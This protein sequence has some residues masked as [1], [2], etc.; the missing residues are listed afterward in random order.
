MSNLIL[1]QRS[2][3]NRKKLAT[4]ISSIAKENNL[5]TEG[6]QKLVLKLISD[7]IKLGKQ[8][9]KRRFEKN[10]NGLNAANLNSFLIDQVIR[11]LYELGTLN[12]YRATN[13]TKSERLA[14]VAIGG[15]GRSELA[16]YSDIDLLFLH[17]YKLAF[18]CEQVIEYILY[19][20]WDL[21]FKLGHS[22]RTVK[23]CIKFSKFDIITKTSILESRY[24]CGDRKLYNQLKE[25]YSKE[26]ITNSKNSFVNSKLIEKNLRYKKFGE[27]RY[28]VEPNI[29]EG[30]GSLRDLQTIFWV[31][32]YSSN[33]EKIDQLLNQKVFTHNEINKY[34]KA[35][36]F[37]W[38]VRF[39]LHYLAG[40]SEER[41]TF[42]HQVEIS[43]KLNFR[44]SKSNTSVERFMKKYYLT[45][46]DVGSLSKI[47]FSNMNSEKITNKKNSSRK[48]EF[49]LNKDEDI[50]VNH[51]NNL[52][53]A[54]EKIFFEKPVNIIKLFAISQSYDIDIHPKTITILIRN[55]YRIYKMR[56]NIESNSIFIKILISK[57]NPEKILRKMNE[58]GFIGRFIPDFGKVVAQT[59]HD[60]YHLYT[61]DEHTIRAIGILNRIESG[62]LSYEH[63]LATTIV[64]KISSRRVLYLSVF[65]HDIAKGQSGDHSILGEKIARDLCPRLGLDEEEV[66]EVAWLVR[67]HLIMSHTAFKRDLGDL[68]TIEDFARFVGIKER[69]N[70]LLLLTISDISAVG[71]NTWN[72][73]KGQLLKNLYEST[74]ELMDGLS[75]TPLNKRISIAKDKLKTKLKWS[76][77]DYNQFV[78]LH[79]DSYWLSND[80][81]SQIRHAN[82]IKNQNFQN[83]V[84]KI[85]GH[86]DTINAITEI[87]VY[88]TD[89]PGLFSSLAGSLTLAGAIVLDA[90]VSTTKNGMALD[91]FWV[92]NSINLPYSNNSDL[93]KLFRYIKSGVQ[94]KSWLQKEYQNKKFDSQQNKNYFE[95]ATKISINNN[96]SNLYTVIEITTHDKLGL[97]YEITESLIKLEL[98]ISSAH[99]ST[100]GKRVV[101]V[102]YVKDLFGL[103]V[104]NKRKINKIIKHLKEKVDTNKKNLTGEKSHIIAA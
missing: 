24:I 8:E 33:I 6:S 74:Y 9:I 95:I 54:N 15:F 65:L 4:C 14:L 41:L 56:N 45:A 80:L 44:N 83:K 52:T 79:Y 72:A 68:K 29:K 22:V 34:K 13:P 53:I 47:F 50:F 96:I 1:D 102:F 58:T 31:A 35:Q 86:I 28:L 3:I 23:D 49:I 40:H 55:L 51:Q 20:L 38:T 64:K 92:Q 67:W 61:V 19:S 70:M 103:K 27:S 97:L 60:M 12:I 78:N 76:K 100:Y 59:Q 85:D 21:G 5:R 16:P 63:N 25:K 99:I 48:I 87:N 7:E 104:T 26:I 32:K 62:E 93:E 88:A 57:K 71:P 46:N 75:E 81:T 66:N 10:Q 73:W 39:W 2:I 77:K 91:S 101:D 18:W 36:V 94:D 69:L 11:T 89:H 37:F 84:L 43:K 42:D 90:K 30:K 98:Q 82:I 17:P